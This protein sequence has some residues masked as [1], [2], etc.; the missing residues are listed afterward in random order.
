MTEKVNNSITEGSITNLPKELISTLQP[1]VSSVILEYRITNFSDRIIYVCTR[2]GVVFEVPPTTITPTGDIV[3][4]YTGVSNVGTPQDH[5]LISTIDGNESKITKSIKESL[6]ANQNKT[7]VIDERINIYKYFSNRSGI[8]LRNSDLVIYIGKDS[9]Q[10]AK[11]I[12]H[13]FCTQY[14]LN[15]FL[16]SVDLC[17]KSSIEVKV[18]LIDNSKTM[19][20]RYTVFHNNVIK[21]RPLCNTT[22]ADGIHI[23]GLVELADDDENSLRTVEYYSLADIESGKA[24]IK[25]FHT[26]DE[27]NTEKK[28]ERDR[29]EKIRLAEV[30]RENSYKLQLVEQ[31]KELE[32]LTSEKERLKAEYELEKLRGEKELLSNK[33]VKEEKDLLIQIEMEKIKLEIAREKA[34]L[35]SKVSQNKQSA[36]TF[37]T[38]S[39]AL[40]VALTITNIFK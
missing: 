10:L 39:I 32:K 37:K 13:P 27:A 5:I 4:T 9:Y 40:G 12:H 21:L 16:T 22:L 1:N 23:T 36:E 6:I 11:S 28:L 24:P 26:F 38:L 18:V 25:L 20:P 3:V 19:S 15:K 30:E 2:Q 34:D 29:E 35:E 14:H 7:Y 17:P 33:Q 8:Y 31:Q